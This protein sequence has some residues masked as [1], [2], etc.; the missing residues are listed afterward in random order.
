MG[1]G[2]CTLA[3]RL[4]ERRN[5]TAKAVRG[6]AE[7]EWTRVRKFHGDDLTGACILTWH[8]RHL[9]IHRGHVQILSRW[10]RGML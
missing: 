2:Y 3:E 1:Q 10:A 6:C 5:A 9:G 8:A 4:A 7:E